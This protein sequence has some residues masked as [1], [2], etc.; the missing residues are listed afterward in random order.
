MNI[1]KEYVAPMMTTMIVE[2]ER[3]FM[4]GSIIDDKGK[5]AKVEAQSQDYHELGADAWGG[6]NDAGITWE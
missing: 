1:K 5:G 3:G 6:N 2:L 4:K